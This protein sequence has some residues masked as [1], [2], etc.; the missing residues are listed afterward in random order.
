METNHSEKLKSLAGYM[1][2]IEGRLKSTENIREEVVIP[3]INELRYA[4]RRFVDAWALSANGWIPEED[5]SAFEDHLIVGHQYLVNADHDITDAVCYFVHGEI[6]WFMKRFGMDEIQK[7]S[8][9][10]IQFAMRMNAANQV[11]T[12]SREDRSK[13]TAAYDK[14]EKEYIPDLLERYEL[15]KFAVPLALSRARRRRLVDVFLIAFGVTGT[16]ITLVG[17]DGVIHLPLLAKTF[18]QLFQIGNH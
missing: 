18:G 15:L 3:G 12:G 4:G 5:R 17:W 8:P 10:F 11:V 14:L 9:D 16:I 1:N 7:V 13:R 2:K 6:K